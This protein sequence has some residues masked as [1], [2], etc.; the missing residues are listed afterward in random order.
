MEL[1]PM[2]NPIHTAAQRFIDDNELRICH[3]IIRQISHDGHINMAQIIRD[4]G[5]TYRGDYYAELRDYIS[6]VLCASKF[7]T[8]Y[9][10]RAK[11]GGPAVWADD[12]DDDQ[13]A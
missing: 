9:Q 5:G 12:D 10:P 11:D 2:D 6:T 7:L 1:P 3:S 8:P 13:H 4:V